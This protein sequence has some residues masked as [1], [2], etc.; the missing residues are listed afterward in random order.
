MDT[1]SPDLSPRPMASPAPMSNTTHPLVSARHPHMQGSS[2]RPS[3][4]SLPTE[5]KLLIL[6]QLDDPNALPN[7]TC[8]SPIY[9]EIGRD[10]REEVC[11]AVTIN[12]VI[13]HGFDPFNAH[14]LVAVSFGKSTTLEYGWNN[15]HEAVGLRDRN[16]KDGFWNAMQEFYKACQQHKNTKSTKSLK[17]P[18]AICKPLW[19]I[20]HAVGWTVHWSYDDV[21][22]ASNGT[23][24]YCRVLQFI[25][26]V[27]QAG[28]R[29]DRIAYLHGKPEFK[30]SP[31]T[32]GSVFLGARTSQWSEYFKV[33]IERT[34]KTAEYPV[35]SERRRDEMSE[36]ICYVVFFLC[37][38]SLLLWWVLI[39]SAQNRE[40]VFK[41]CLEYEGWD[42]ARC[43][44]WMGLSE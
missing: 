14:D 43:L 36:M 34:I 7:L 26:I 30:C 21:P 12:Y 37:F 4:E 5:I 31:Y 29:T 39:G 3:L 27:L 13:R 2:D 8:A 10:K 18:V 9:F 23:A 42:V 35:R 40:R 17:L 19:Q 41:R 25:Y 15:I 20:V 28:T 16:I 38:M 44:E 32:Y 11:T 1:A 6:G 24:D 22:R 33:K